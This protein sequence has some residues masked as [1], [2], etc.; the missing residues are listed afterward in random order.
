MYLLY[1]IENPA[2]F[3]GTKRHAPKKSD[4]YENAVKHPDTAYSAID[5]NKHIHTLLQFFSQGSLYPPSLQT[6]RKKK[7]KKKETSH[8]TYASWM[9]GMVALW[10]FLRVQDNSSHSKTLWVVSGARL[11][12]IT[13]LSAH[14]NLYNNFWKI[15]FLKQFLQIIFGQIY[16]KISW[17]LSKL[18][19]CFWTHKQKGREVNDV[20][21]LHLCTHR[22]P[23]SYNY[24]VYIFNMV[25]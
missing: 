23:N 21:V 20:S 11:R 24:F 22:S 7:E 12:K 14:K 8:S 25:Y 4:K 6:A 17:Q 13:A 18:V 3:Y 9:P 5:Q 10:R 19:H 2:L 1:L 16:A 15:F